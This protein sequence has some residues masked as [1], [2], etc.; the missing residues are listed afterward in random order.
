MF[1]VAGVVSIADTPWAFTDGGIRV[2]DGD[3]WEEL[4]RTS[5]NL[6]GLARQ[7][8]VDIRSSLEKIE[9]IAEKQSAERL[10][11]GGDLM[12]K[13]RICNQQAGDERAHPHGQA[14]VFG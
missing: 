7:G 8:I 12:T 14:Q 10:D 6:P 5:I 3:T 1:D 9:E 11:F 2:L 13:G 4:T